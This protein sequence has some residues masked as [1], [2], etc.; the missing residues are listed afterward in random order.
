M[1]HDI[2]PYT[3]IVESAK[4]WVP[5]G[6]NKSPSPDSDSTVRDSRKERL[7]LNT[8]TYNC[9]QC[10][11]EHSHSSGYMF[12]VRYGREAPLYFCDVDCCDIWEKSITEFKLKPEPVTDRRGAIAATKAKNEETDSRN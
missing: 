4:G 8:F 11:K 1:T 5:Q 12:I 3:K 10:D 6:I 7:A 9:H 2:N